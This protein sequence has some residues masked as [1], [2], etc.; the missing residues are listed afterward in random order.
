MQQVSSAK[1]EKGM[2]KF[3]FF[4]KVLEML[5]L[6]GEYG[7]MN[8]NLVKSREGLPLSI[9]SASF[10][11]FLAVL[12]AVYYRIPR[13]GQWVVLLAASALFYCAAGLRTAG[14]ILLTAL[15]TYGAALWIDREART[16]KARLAAGRET[17]SREEKTALK[18]RSTRK[19]RRIMA[20]AMVFNFG[21][22]CAFKYFHF[23]LAQVNHLIGAFGGRE[24]LDT[25]QILVPLGVSFYTFQSMGYLA[26]VYWGKAEAQGNFGKLL[27]FVSF[28]PQI[29]QGPISSYS[30]LADQLYAPH[31]FT[32]ENYAWGA[33]RMV[34]GYFKKMVLANMLAP[35]VN[36]VF[37]NY[38]SYGSPA[39]LV[40]IFCY[41]MQIYGDFSGYMDIMCGLCQILDIRLTENF[42]RPYFSKSIAEYWR[43]WHMSLGTWFKNYIYYPIA[44]S[45]WNK[46]IGKWAQK[47]LGK[48][49]GRTLPASIA[50]VA[51]WLTTGL[52]HGASWGYIAW[53]GVNGLFIIFSLWMEP[54][55][56]K[57]KKALGIREGS[58]WFRAFQVIRTFLMVSFIKVLP[59]VGGLRRGL[60]LWK[61]AFA[62]WSLPK[63]V[64][65]LFPYGVTK[66]QLC[67]VAAAVGLV[68]LTSL[69]QRREPVR[70][71]FN[72]LPLAARAAVLGILLFLILY[73]GVPASGSVGG[74]LYAQF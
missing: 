59:E 44:V 53:G 40:G 54:V 11:L 49:V 34:W 28:F 19:K 33:Q 17:L 10:I 42:D 64:G 65:E 47:K 14:Y 7:T 18:K 71:R 62:A 36:A 48:T 61:R 72:R 8:Q 13:R 15:S 1:T 74:F 45:G 51:V 6:C 63:S 38:E 2:K 56:A 70:A 32:Y 73:F 21:M 43:R 66:E 29:T 24:I 69:F 27:L 37:Q 22:L 60:G 9:V 52:W 55:Y 12:T 41:S 20:L 31:S 5:L 68:F 58:G 39:V 46:K 35:W 23:A 4:G 26:D 50:L 30:E 16:Q 3:D 57:T 25:F 67:V